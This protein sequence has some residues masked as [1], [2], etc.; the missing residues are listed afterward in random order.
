[1]KKEKKKAGSGLSFCI[2]LAVY[3]EK[4]ICAPFRADGDVTAS[5]LADPDKLN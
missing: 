5:A 1:M 4:K 2:T 3:V